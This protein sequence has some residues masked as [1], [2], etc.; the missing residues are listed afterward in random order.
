MCFL[1]AVKVTSATFGRE[2]SVRCLAARGSTPFVVFTFE[3]I[4]PN[5]TTRNEGEN[6]CVLWKGAAAGRQ[7]LPFQRKNRWAG[8]GSPRCLAPIFSWTET[9]LPLAHHNETTKRWTVRRY[10]TPAMEHIMKLRNTVNTDQPKYTYVECIYIYAMSMCIYIY[11]YIYEYTYIYIYIHLRVME[12]RLNTRAHENQLVLRNVSSKF[13]LVMCLSP[14]SCHCMM[15]SA[16]TCHWGHGLVFHLLLCQ[17][18]TTTF[19]TPVKFYSGSWK[20]ILKISFWGRF[21]HPER[22]KHM[23]SLQ[24]IEANDVF[25]VFSTN[26]PRPWIPRLWYSS[27]VMLE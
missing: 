11:K 13:P 6:V 16:F 26:A 7:I 24:K 21:H 1:G 22:T 10:S 14:W 4:G 8:Q 18:S 2:I 20:G 5:W 12:S 3:N 9:G 23:I 19:S 25:F 17:K 27:V 15:H